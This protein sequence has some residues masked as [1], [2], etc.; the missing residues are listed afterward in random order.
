MKKLFQ[1]IGIGILST[2]SVLLMSYASVGAVEVLD[3][4]CQANPNS[5]ACIESKKTQTPTDNSLYGPNGI[6]TKVVRIISTVLG[7]AA[8]IVV[9]IGGFK[10]SLS[11]GDPKSA[12]SAKNTI[13]FAIIGLVI[14]AV[15]QGIVIFVL[16]KL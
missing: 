6:L 12:E 9:I 14:A 13:L 11:S 15:A 7:I 8:V 16:N 3:P 1:L 4:V 10:Y 5:V 2:G